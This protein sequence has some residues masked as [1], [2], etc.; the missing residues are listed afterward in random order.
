[1]ECSFL[2]IQAEWRSTTH[3]N[4]KDPKQLLNP[5][6][7]PTEKNLQTNKP[8]TKGSGFATNHSYLDGKGW[9]P[10]PVL[11]GDNFRT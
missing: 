8:K 6:Y 5:T 3:E 10:D 11:K 7:H 2:S 1:M 9:N 4:F